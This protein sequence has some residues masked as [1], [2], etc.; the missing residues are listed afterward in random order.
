MEQKNIVGRQHRLVAAGTCPESE[1]T[2]SLFAA[3]AAVAVGH[4]IRAGH[5]G[6]GPVLGTC[7]KLCRVIER[8]N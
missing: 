2:G 7:R 3:A 4:N 6:A 5:T 8:P 1:S